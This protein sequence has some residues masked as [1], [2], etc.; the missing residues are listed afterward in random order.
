MVKAKKISQTTPGLALALCCIRLNFWML[1][2]ET[3][4]CKDKSGSDIAGVI[5][6]IL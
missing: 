3:R 5:L 1:H 2:L 4:R 6:T